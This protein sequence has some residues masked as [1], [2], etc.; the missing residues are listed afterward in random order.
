MF[1]AIKSRGS[2]G[3]PSQPVALPPTF[4]KQTAPALRYAGS[5]RKRI[6]LKLDKIGRSR[7]TKRAWNPDPKELTTNISR[8]FPW[9][10][11]LPPFIRNVHGSE[12]TDSK[13]QNVTDI[14]K[15]TLPRKYG[16]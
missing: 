4:K 10:N 3:A 8:G 5:S 11:E 7:N 13:K 15:Q 2:N 14:N 1:I 9:K 16:V 12:S 6:P